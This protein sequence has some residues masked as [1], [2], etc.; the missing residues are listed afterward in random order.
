[1]ACLPRG[2]R[3]AP[4]VATVVPLP[5]KRKRGYN[6]SM[7]VEALKLQRKRESTR[8]LAGVMAVATMVLTHQLLCHRLTST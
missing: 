4:L 3:I 7:S 6:A 5:N 8:I 1:M 2:T